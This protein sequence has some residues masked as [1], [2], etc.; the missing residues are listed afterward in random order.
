MDQDIEK[1]KEMAAQLRCPQ[2]EKGLEVADLMNQTNISMTLKALDAL[3]FEPG[4]FVL[5]I[6]PGSCSHLH[7]IVQRNGNIKYT[8]LDISP[9]MIDEAGKLN[10][11]YVDEQTAEF[12]L[13]DGKKI[14]FEE[15]SFN[16]ILTVNTVYFWENPAEFLQEIYRVLKP[17]G[18]FSLCFAQK[19]F[20][21]KVPFT[22]YGFT[23]YNTE[24]MLQLIRQTPFRV[25][26]IYHYSEQIKAK[27][28]EE[29]TRTFS[30]A[31]LKKE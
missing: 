28:G 30:V 16:R 4:D 21:E 31:L 13:Y 12:V 6:G 10:R 7:H 19:E 26:N 17:E 5:E 24:D 9:L 25:K 14:P 2:G 27:S 18:Q 15:N 11:K 20:M 1:L 29:I 3:H 22:V 23:K 8:G